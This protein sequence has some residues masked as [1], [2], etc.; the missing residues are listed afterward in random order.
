MKN[1]TIIAITG[2]IGSGKSA[3]CNILQN[4]GCQVICADT[5]GR[6]IL[7]S[8]K[9]ALTKEFRQEITLPSGEIDRKKIASLVFSDPKNLKKLNNL[10]H[11]KILEELEKLIQKSRNSLIFVE[12]PPVFFADVSRCFDSIVQIATSKSLLNQRLQAKDQTFLERI[13]SQKNNSLLTKSSFKIKN[14]KTVKELENE[15]KKLLERCKTIQQTWKKPFSA[16]FLPKVCVCVDENELDSSQKKINNALECKHLAEFRLDFLKKI[17]TNLKNW[18]KKNVIATLRTKSQ[19]GQSVLGGEKYA[20]AI[21]KID[22]LGFE[23]IDIE[24]ENAEF[25]NFAKI[26]SKIIVSYHNFYSTPQNLDEIAQKMQRFSPFCIKIATMINDINDNFLL[27]DL[28]KKHGNL[29]AFGMGEKGEFSRILSLKYGSLFTYSFTLEKS[30][31]APG[32]IDIESLHNLYN[33]HKIGSDTAIYG[34]IGQN[35]GKSFSRF[36]HNKQFVRKNVDACFVNFPIDSES[37]LKNFLQNFRTYG[38]SGLAVTMPHKQSVFQLVDSIDSTACKIKAINTIH[39]KTG[40]LLGYNTDWLGGIEP[41]LQ[42]TSLA[43]KKVLL[44]GNGGAAKAIFFGLIREKALVTVAARNPEKSQP[45]LKIGDFSSIDIETAQ[46]S[47]TEFDVIINAT[48]VGMN[49]EKSLLTKFKAGQFVMDIVYHPR[50][51]KLLQL[52]ENQK[53]TIIL[54]EEMLYSQ[55]EEQEKIWL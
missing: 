35:I 1:K 15:A 28:L 40:K 25:I 48:K 3:F 39:S 7:P 32:Q 11:P 55:A 2:T 4:L 22:K 19:G 37:E 41:L 14:D 24:L 27:F 12:I 8:L 17:P 5:I 53:A 46:K 18:N 54:G 29:I 23:F 26:K 33:I 20:E 47:S 30:A 49:E 42:R 16:V 9:N 50:K 34:L 52:A 43:G 51:T 6:Q 10:T 31:V 36:Y 38:W 45:L 44:L 13:N 21:Y